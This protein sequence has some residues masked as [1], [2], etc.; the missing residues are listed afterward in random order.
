M[1]GELL[2]EKRKHRGV[3]LSAAA[4]AIGT[5]KSHLFELESGR[6]NNPTIAL[7]VPMMAYYR[8]SWSEVISAWEPSNAE[9]SGG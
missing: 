2:K 3:S 4:A 9:V 8:L 5:T 7:L 6:T 1:L